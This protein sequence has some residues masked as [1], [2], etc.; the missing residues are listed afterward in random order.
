MQRQRGCHAQAEAPFRFNDE[1]LMRC[2]MRTVDWAAASPVLE[3]W[4]H[5]KAA[6]YPVAGGYADQPALFVDLL[7]EVDGFNAECGMRSAE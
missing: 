2:P 4:P 5:L 7:A 3:M 6:R 1:D